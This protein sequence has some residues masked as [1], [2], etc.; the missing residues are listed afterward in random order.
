MKF[1]SLVLFLSANLYP[2]PCEIDTSIS[3]VAPSDKVHT[4]RSVLT[5]STPAGHWICAANTS[6][7]PFAFTVKV[8]FSWSSTFKTNLLRFN[9]RS[10]TSS[11]TP[12][13]DVNSW[14]TPSIFIPVTATPGTL[15]RRALLIVLPKVRPKPGSKGSITNLDL[16]FPRSSCVISGLCSINIY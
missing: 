14:L 13:I 10:N 4:L 8:W 12:G 2:T 5:T 16:L 11:T 15:E 1:E 3:N 7:G 9:K 6:P